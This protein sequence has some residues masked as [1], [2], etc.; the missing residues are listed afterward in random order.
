MSER[1][2]RIEAILETSTGRLDRVEAIQESNGRSIEALSS[3]ISD[4]TNNVTDLSNQMMD[5]KSSID[6]VLGRNA[7]TNDMILE[8]RA[9]R[10]QDQRNFEQ[11]QATTNA[12]LNQLTAILMRLSQ[13]NN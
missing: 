1:L 8:L 10:E 3:K 11:H 4:L 5:L 9:A 13:N 6:S 12:A 2:D 7:I